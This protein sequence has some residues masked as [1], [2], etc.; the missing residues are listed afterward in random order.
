MRASIS[1]LENIETSSLTIE[2]ESTYEVDH[3]YYENQRQEIFADY[4]SLDPEIQASLT[5]ARQELPT[6]EDKTWEEWQEELQQQR[7][8][9]MYTAQKAGIMKDLTALKATVKQLLDIN[10][11]LPEIERLPISAFDLDRV[12]RD[13][14]LKVARDEREEV[15]MEL[16]HLCESMDNVATWIKSTFWDTQVILGRSIFSFAG[17]IE[18]TNY[19]ML[20]KDPY[21]KDYLHWAQFN[22]DAERVVIRG[23]TFQSWRAYTDKQLQIELSKS[24][25]VYHEDEKRKMDVLL[26]EEEREIDP[27]ELVELRMLDG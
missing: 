11:T 4:A 23:D 17:D 21:F 7:E 16:E 12:G 5:R 25:T 6:S 10:E 9:K 15:R 19:P 3:S 24:L 14:K 1:I 22:R 27:E 18:V 8:E 13:H 20:E 2:T 26:E